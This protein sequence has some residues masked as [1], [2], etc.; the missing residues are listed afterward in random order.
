M[1]RTLTSLACLGLALTASACG[2]DAA[3][4]W[5]PVW[6]AHEVAMLDAVNAVRAEGAVCGET[7]YPPT[8]PLALDATIQIASRGHSLDMATQD[9]FD[10]ASLDGRSFS[11]R[12]EA[13]GFAG[14]YPWGE[15]IQAGAST[16]AEAVASLLTSPPH[17]ENM[18][19]P[20]YFVA[21]FGYAS[22][23]NSTYEHYWTQNFAGGH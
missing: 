16:A 5:N 4:P 11:D 10:H 23:P 9:F 13:T 6:A 8:H 20:E 12:M 18:M 2:D 15:N 7:P 19:S 3:T 21:G 14:A 22:D 17:C 1:S